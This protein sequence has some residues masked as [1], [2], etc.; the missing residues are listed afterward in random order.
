MFC[1]YHETAK[2]IP[3]IIA[4]SHFCVSQKKKHA[5]NEWCG[6]RNEGRALL[7]M[8]TKKGIISCVNELEKCHIVMI[9]KKITAANT[10]RGLWHCKTVDKKIS[11]NS[12]ARELRNWMYC[13][14]GIFEQI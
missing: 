3:E 4:I 11:P 12:L 2:R 14:N 5:K 1:S 10:N 7:I 13:K 9:G 6:G 8:G